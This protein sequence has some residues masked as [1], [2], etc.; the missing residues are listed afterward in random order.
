MKNSI[1]IS[2]FN[3]IKPVVNI[4]APYVGLNRQSRCSLFGGITWEEELAY[5]LASQK[6]RVEKEMV[7]DSTVGGRTSTDIKT[8]LQPWLNITKIIKI[9]DYT[10]VNKIICSDSDSTTRLL[11][12]GLKVFNSLI[13]PKQMTLETYTHIVICYNCYK[14][15]THATKD[16][17]KTTIICLE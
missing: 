1:W 12:D 3:I 9:K 15:E 4:P 5:R 17:T 13:T 16:C 6:G 14:Y 2:Y 8:R 11:T 7:I 10:H